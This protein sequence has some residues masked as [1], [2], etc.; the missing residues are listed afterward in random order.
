MPLYAHIKTDRI[1]GWF[2]ILNKNVIFNDETDENIKAEDLAFMYDLED[3]QVTVLTQR[4]TSS[5]DLLTNMLGQN[6]T[7]AE[8]LMKQA[9]Q[10]WS[11]LRM[12]LRY[13]QKRRFQP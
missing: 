10:L 9:V 8:T 6:P 1:D 2:R 12:H 11:F 4:L 7:P 3:W 5:P 13:P